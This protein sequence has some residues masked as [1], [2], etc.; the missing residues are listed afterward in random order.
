MLPLERKQEIVKLII[1]NKSIKVN[2]MSSLFNVTEETIRRD[3]EKLEKENILK[4]TYGGAVVIETPGEDLSFF[5]RVREHMDEKKKLAKYVAEFIKDGDTIMLDSSTTALE[6]GKTIQ[7]DRQVTIITN[8]LNACLELSANSHLKIISIGG[9]LNTRNMSFEG[10][11]AVKNLNNYY[12]DKV[13]FSCKGVDFERGIMESSEYVAEIKQGMIQ[14][15]KQVILV[16][17]Q[18]KFDKTS[19]VRI[20]DFCKV[21]VL[22]T[23]LKIDERWMS[24][25]EKYDIQ[26][27]VIEE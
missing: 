26:V 22:I 10:P 9:I 2:E 1:N 27:I 7:D 6:V 3:L 19:L 14:S 24:Q 23:N 18:S 16:V 15:A 11:A 21:D 4:R 20:D 5:E 12:A 8:S 17:D 25:L 13:I